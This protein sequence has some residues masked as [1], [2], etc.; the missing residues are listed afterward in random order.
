MKPR[1]DNRWGSTVNGVKDQKQ[2]S[3]AHVSTNLKKA[4]LQDERYAEIELENFKLLEKLSRILERSHNPTEGTREWGN[5]VRLDANQVPVID[6]A[7]GANSYEFGAAVKPSSLNLVYRKQQQERIAWE[8]RELVRRLQQSRPTY[9]T[10]KFEQDASEREQWQRE[11]RMPVR[12]YG[13]QLAT[14]AARKSRPASAPIPRTPPWQHAHASNHPAQQT[15]GMANQATRRPRPQTAFVRNRKPGVQPAGPPPPPN[16]YVSQVLE[17]LRIS[18][19]CAKGSTNLDEM[20]EARDALM[21]DEFAK[22]ERVSL[23]TISTPGPSSVEIEIVDATSADG[24]APTAANAL[25]LLVH[26]GMFMSGS[27]RG[28]RHLA[29]RLSRELGMPVAA[30][31]LRLAPE[32]RCPAPYDDLMIA[33]QHIAKH[34]AVEPHAVTSTAPEAAPPE[35]LA[36]FAESSGCMVTLSLIHRLLREAN[37]ARLPDALVMA[38]PWLDL[39][40]SGGSFFINQACD[41]VLQ[42][43]KLLNVASSFVADG[44]DPKDPRISPI[45][46]LPEAFKNLPPTLVH[47]GDNEVVLD[48]SRKLK[49]VCPE[50]V[51]LH[52]FKD[53]LHAWHTFFPIMPQAREAL[54]EV[55][56]FL[57]GKLGL[58]I[59]EAHA[60]SATVIAAFGLDAPLASVAEA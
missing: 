15:V 19:K 7:V 18:M 44:M 11:R 48:D 39:T 12:L 23:R 49:D 14:A 54:A 21:E 45:L 26:G 55:E 42:Q 50:A 33:Y 25:L 46:A 35:K 60:A 29:A 8:N 5:G 3:Y 13:S 51:E 24:A 52:E 20:R 10:A 16:E 4:Q 28:V 32:H 22:M 38:S 56:T 36:V 59:R 17:H 40:C 2:P 6:H 57:R 1:I 9:D 47:V 53:V 37:S 41:P 58:P 27:P 34:G 30:P 31:R 43:G